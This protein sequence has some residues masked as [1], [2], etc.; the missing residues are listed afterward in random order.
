MWPQRF[1][2]K[3]VPLHYTIIFLSMQPNVPH[4][5]GNFS[6]RRQLVNHLIESFKEVNNRLTGWA[7]YIAYDGIERATVSKF[8]GKMHYFR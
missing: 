2:V 3:V 7:F 6:R 5:F 8:S 4:S 1:C